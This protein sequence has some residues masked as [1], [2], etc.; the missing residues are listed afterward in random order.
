MVEVEVEVEVAEMVATEEET[1]KL[2]KE[3]T[4][5]DRRTGALARM[6]IERPRTI[7]GPDAATRP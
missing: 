2:K 4:R 1:R 7:S 6:S 5:F 3:R